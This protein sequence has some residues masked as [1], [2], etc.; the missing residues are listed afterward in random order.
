MVQ[1]IRILVSF[2]F[3]VSSKLIECLFFTNKFGIELH[4][5][6]HYLFRLALDS[7]NSA[8]IRFQH[9]RIDRELYVLV[10]KR[11]QLFCFTK[12]LLSL[13]E[14]VYVNDR[15]IC[16]YKLARKQNEY[17]YKCTGFIFEFLA[18]FRFTEKMEKNARNTIPTSHNFLP[19]SYACRGQ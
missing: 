6:Q 16:G 15:T 11:I 12:L 7:L 13:T 10:F 3:V 14:N 1:D 8:E 2:T 19:D 17:V 9:Y 5:R 18:V 4:F